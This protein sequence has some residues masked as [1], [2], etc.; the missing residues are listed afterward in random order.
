M[1]TNGTL[2][3]QTLSMPVVDLD[4]EPCQSVETWSEPIPCSIKTNSDNRKGVYEDGEFRIAS[5]LVLLEADA[6]QN[7]D[8]IKRVKLSRGT[9]NLGEYRVLSSEPIVTQGRF[10]I[11]V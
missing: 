6:S 2:Q 9:E 4:G 8:A 7:F 5:F 11:I 3:F 1:R 10:Q